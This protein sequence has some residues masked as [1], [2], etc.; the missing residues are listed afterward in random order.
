MDKYLKVNNKTEFTNP[1]FTRSKTTILNPLLYCIQ[2]C[3]HKS[4]FIRSY[5]HYLDIIDKG[6]QVFFVTAT[7]S[8]E[9]LSYFYGVPC[10][11]Y[12]RMRKFLNGGFRKFVQRHFHCKLLTICHCLQLCPLNKLYK[13][14]SYN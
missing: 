8:N 13:A 2:E 1:L 10:F 4:Y 7:F 11:D 12:N 14:Y 3:K 9:N 5:Y 6:G